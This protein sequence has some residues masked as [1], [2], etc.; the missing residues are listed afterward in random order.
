MKYIEA[1]VVIQGAVKGEDV[2]LV[3]DVFSDFG[4]QGVVIEAPD[5]E[6]A[7][8][9][10]EDA[11][12]LPDH[13]GVIGY[14]PKNRLA[15]SRCRR[16]E[17]RLLQLKSKT[18]LDTR[19]HYREIDET[20][21]A[22]SWKAFFFP[23]RL[24]DRIIVKPTWREVDCGPEDIILEIDPGMA[25]G[26]GIHPTTAACIQMIQAFL[27]AGDRLLDVGTGSGI[28]ML[29]G[30]RLGASHV[31]GVDI[32]ETAVE[33]AEK[34]LRRNG[35]PPAMATVR[36][37]RLIDGVRGR[38][39]LVTANILS[40]VILALLDDVETV[41]TRGGILIASGI[42]EKNADA[43]MD[44]MRSKDLDVVQVKQKEGWTTIA[45]RMGCSVESA[46]GG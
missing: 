46:A 19:V 4:L 15:A 8:E 10:G 29:A 1:K 34:N 13:H 2:E 31:Y 21:W 45:A 23:Q 11:V 39:D 14:F 5:L 27:H 6:P 16:L 33:I 37:G 35:I 7:E 41:L 42:I 40:E 12:A 3:A 30:A 43:V 32:D 20:D 22:H 36:C 25:F 24:T 28:L 17:G 44:K 18:G 9:W 38:F 26:T